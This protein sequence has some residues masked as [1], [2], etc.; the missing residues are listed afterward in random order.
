MGN[1]A[2]SVLAVLVILLAVSLY[3]GRAAAE[4]TAGP[5]DGILI[6]DAG[7]RAIRVLPTEV[8]RVGPEQE[9][10]APGRWSFR[11]LGYSDFELPINEPAK[12]L[13]ITYVLPEDAS[14]GPDLWYVLHTRVHLEFAP[15]TG[16][17][18]AYLY[19]YANGG[20][21]GSI[22]LSAA[23]D[24]DVEV[25]TIT[26]GMPTILNGKHEFAN[27]STTD[28]SLDLELAAYLPGPFLEWNGVQPGRNSLA[29]R[30]SQRNG[31]VMNSATISADSYLELTSMPPADYKPLS[32]QL[33]G[34]P[35]LPE[36]DFAR[37]REIVLADAAVQELLA[38]KGF[39][40]DF[41]APWDLP[42][43]E[44]DREI[45]VD[46][47]L[48]RPYKIEGYVWPWPP[49]PVRTKPIST[50]TRWVEAMTIIIS[51]LENGQVLGIMPERHPGVALPPYEPDPAIP[52]LTDEQKTR[53]T[54][55]ALA[56][57]TVQRILA[58]GT[59]SIERIGP[60]YISA[61]NVL[62]GA[63]VE[64]AFADVQWMDEQWLILDFDRQ[65][66]AFPYYSV[67]A[68]EEG[69]YVEGLVIL[70]DF[71]REAAVVVMPRVMSFGGAA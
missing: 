20:S 8:A 55:L 31:R 3:V 34:Q 40:F 4:R 56:H 11:D 12:L 7:H 5:A 29:F 65:K 43:T 53:A 60:W 35:L 44:S 23:Y 69:Y 38:G 46:V 22:I 63:A 70:V 42:Q 17:R 2:F 14:Q 45:R 68:Q 41:A 27:G 39:T 66:Y 36:Q 71:G 16:S 57:P 64:I 32:V 61:E 48:D 51:G 52:R 49:A 33:E 47:S 24:P 50:T 19:A 9:I 54:E 26:W 37:A 30:A 1:R 59:Y 15:G 10:A 6:T 67:S 28:F 13:S 62:I 21:A 18:S 58:S 25:Q